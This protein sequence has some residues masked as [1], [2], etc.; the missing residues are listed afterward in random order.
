MVKTQKYKIKLS[1]EERIELLNILNKDA[2]TEKQKKRANILL[3][4][5]RFYYIGCRYRPQESVASRCG[6]ST[7]TV[8]N[9]SKK[10]VEEGLHAV[11]NR[12]VR[13]KPPVT[14]IVTGDIEAEIIALA[15]SAPPEGNSRWTLRLLETK[16]VELKIIESISD[17]TIGRVLK[18]RQINL[19]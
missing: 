4:L 16:A 6:V 13:E 3:E 2:Y 7:T 12:K 19:I 14:S 5:D 9:I 1:K 17:T 8:Y 11:I 10:Y 15:C 18:K